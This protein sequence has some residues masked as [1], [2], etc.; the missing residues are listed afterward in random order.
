ML[1][2]ERLLIQETLNGGKMEGEN[3]LSLQLRM[4]HIT[5][6]FIQ[7]LLGELLILLKQEHR[8]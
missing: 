4:N 7:K 8:F 6:L 3:T 2:A 5:E 1:W